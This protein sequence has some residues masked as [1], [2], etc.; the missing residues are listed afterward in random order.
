MHIPGKMSRRHRNPSTRF[1]RQWSARRYFSKLPE[2][3]SHELMELPNAQQV[4]QIAGN[5]RRLAMWQESCE[6][7]N[8]A[9]VVRNSERLALGVRRSRHVK[10]VAA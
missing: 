10:A 5:A 2:I 1:F 6:Q 7:A 3:R 8:E 4:A 9:Y